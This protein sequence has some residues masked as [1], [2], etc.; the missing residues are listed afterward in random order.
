MA[1]G[2]V[3]DDNGV[4]QYIHELDIDDESVWQSVEPL[5]SEL[6]KKSIIVKTRKSFG[7]RIYWKETKPHKNITQHACYPSGKFELK[8]EWG[9][10]I[11]MGSS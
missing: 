3:I 9:L 11:F 6:R 1:L 4:V 7:K 2:E 10:G 8:S 5:M